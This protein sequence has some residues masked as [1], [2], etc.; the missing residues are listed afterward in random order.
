[1]LRLH[2]SSSALQ[3]SCSLQRRQAVFCFRSVLLKK[4]WGFMKGDVDYTGLSSWF[5][6]SYRSPE[7]FTRNSLIQIENKFSFLSVG[8][9]FISTLWLLWICSLSAIA[10]H[11]LFMSVWE[12]FTAS[13][14]SEIH[15]SGLLVGLL[16]CIIFCIKFSAVGDSFPQKDER[17]KNHSVPTCK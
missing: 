15:C 8:K 14:R 17:K 6:F 5:K 10:Q 4:C 13:I 11:I 1:M 16:P 7:F 9:L 2:K 12:F 3:T